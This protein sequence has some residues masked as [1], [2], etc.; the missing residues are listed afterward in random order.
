MRS[1]VRFAGMVAD[2]VVRVA[3]PLGRRRG[4]ALTLVGWHRIG[5]AT[6]GL[7]TTL[8]DFQRHLDVLEEWGAIVLPLDEAH[9]MLVAGELPER[10][11]ALTFDDGYASV[12]EQAWPLLRQRGL[13]ATLFAV[14]GYLRPGAR[15]PWDEGHRRGDDLVRLLT[16]PE[17][18]AAAA[19]GLDIGSHTVTHRWLP[20]LGDDEVR[21]E[22]VRS[23]ADLEDL[24]AR[25][26]RSFAYPMGGWNPALR[27]AVEAAGY[28]L[29]IT[30]ERGRNRADQHPASLRRAFAFDRADDVRRQLDGAF[31]WMRP[32]E[33][34]RALREPTW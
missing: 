1:Q 15:F 29:A 30:T 8:P 22:L 32:I 33:R 14:S 31:T 11:V 5:D 21:E 24:L 6:D 2:P 16:A 26:V 9:R 19:E 17:L 18:C 13:P 20:G 4:A 10:A 25:P 7:T 3:R 12:V 34:R 23:R 27:S 28:D